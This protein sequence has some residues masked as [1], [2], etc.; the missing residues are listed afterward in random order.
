M[1]NGC[2]M[3]INGDFLVNNGDLPLVNIQKA[4]ELTS[5]KGYINYFYGHFQ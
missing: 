4:M 5:L 3:V 2:F 1:T